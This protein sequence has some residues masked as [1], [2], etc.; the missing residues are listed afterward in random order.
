MWLMYQRIEITRASIMK[1]IIVTTEEKTLKNVQDFH[2]MAHE[3][4]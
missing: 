3:T 4:E 1:I 2:Q